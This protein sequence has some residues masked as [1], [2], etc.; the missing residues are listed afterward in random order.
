MG[1]DVPVIVATVWTMR[2]DVL[3]RG[4]HPNVAASAKNPDGMYRRLSKSVH[5]TARLGYGS[6]PLAG[7]PRANL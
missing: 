4:E 3:M 7:K 6:F 5:Q 1:G 2:K